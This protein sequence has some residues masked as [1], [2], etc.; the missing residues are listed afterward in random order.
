MSGLWLAAADEGGMATGGEGQWAMGD[1]QRRR[2]RS[3]ASCVAA[4]NRKQGRLGTNEMQLGLELNGAL[5]GWGCGFHW[6]KG[7]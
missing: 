4:A 6:P 7:K 5:G 3:V 2:R 1:G